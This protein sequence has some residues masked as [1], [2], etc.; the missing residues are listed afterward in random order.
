[1][2][3]NTQRE[4]WVRKDPEQEWQT[5]KV[6]HPDYTD[7]VRIVANTFKEQTFGGEVY[8]PAPMQMKEPE[9]AEDLKNTASVTFPRAAILRQKQIERNHEQQLDTLVARIEALE[10]V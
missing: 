8:L 1:M 6:S 2:T 9:N 7:A 10:A 4:F 3:T 5:L